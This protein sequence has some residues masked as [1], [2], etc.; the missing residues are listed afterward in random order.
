MLTRLSFNIPTLF[1]QNVQ[2][3]LKFA[4]GL[5]ARNQSYQ[6]Y[7]V[8]MWMELR[9]LPEENSAREIPYENKYTARAKTYSSYR[10]RDTS[11]TYGCKKFYYIT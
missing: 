8:I 2:F 11:T 5:F 3:T 7:I 6:V 9:Y 1:V 4:W 10:G